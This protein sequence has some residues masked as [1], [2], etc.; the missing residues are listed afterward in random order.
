MSEVKTFRISGKM[1]LSIDWVP[2]SKEIRALKEEHALEKL[3]SLLGSNHKV[4]RNLIVIE[5]IEVIS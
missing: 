4:R 5:K 1:R 2:F 3:Y